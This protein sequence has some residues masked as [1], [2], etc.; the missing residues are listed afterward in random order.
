MINSRTYWI[1]IG[2]TQADD[3]GDFTFVV[4]SG[5]IRVTAFTGE[6]DLDSG[7]YNYVWNG[8]AMSELL[9]RTLKQKCKTVTGILGE[10]YGSTWLKHVVNVSGSDG[11]SN[12]EQ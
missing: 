9:Q 12:G 6:V 3:N 7:I 8:Y 11:H 10:V 1:P 4:P 5:K 2:T